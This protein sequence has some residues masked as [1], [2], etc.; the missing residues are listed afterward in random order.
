MC[1]RLYFFLASACEGGWPVL[2]FAAWSHHQSSD[3][4]GVGLPIR[5][6]QSRLW[7]AGG[8]GISKQMS[9][10]PIL[11]HL[12][13]QL[14]QEKESIVV[15]MTYLSSMDIFKEASGFKLSQML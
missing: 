7:V 15:D 9:I 6:L 14:M 2:F 3:T 5:L 12:T 4:V 1:L 13:K 11:A 10:P 8:E